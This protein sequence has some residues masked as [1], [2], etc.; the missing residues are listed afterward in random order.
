MEFSLFQIENYKV[1]FEVTAEMEESFSKVQH[2]Q[3]ARDQ[4]C[5]RRKQTTF[6]WFFTVM[7]SPT[8][9]EG[10]KLVLFFWVVVPW[11]VQL[12]NSSNW[13]PKMSAFYWQPYINKNNVDIKREQKRRRNILPLSQWQINMLLVVGQIRLWVARTT[14]SPTTSTWRKGQIHLMQQRDRGHPQ[15]KRWAR[16]QAPSMPFLW[17]STQL[18]QPLCELG[19][20]SGDNKHPWI[21]HRAL[22]NEDSKTHLRPTRRLSTD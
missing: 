15:G 7:G 20:W 13:T 16:I 6:C 3:P 21:T 10:V 17:S 4:T 5:A 12:A 2:H 22:G 9:K 11:G 14:G 8:A 1:L 19:P 18:I